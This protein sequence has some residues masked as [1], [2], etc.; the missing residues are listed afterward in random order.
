MSK[1]QRIYLELIAHKWL[2]P[3]E[4]RRAMGMSNP[5]AAGGIGSVLQRLCRDGLAECE[6]GAYRFHATDA[7]RAALIPSGE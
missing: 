2:T 7:G 3:H 1:A 5:R 4:I 6:P